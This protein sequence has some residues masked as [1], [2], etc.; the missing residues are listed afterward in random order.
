MKF[1][2]DIE[3]L[4]AVA[5]IP[6]VLFHANKQLVPGG[7]IG[8]DVFFV[9]SGFLI[10]RIIFDGVGNGSFSFFGFYRKRIQRIFPALFFML[11]II[12]ALAIWMLPPLALIEYGKT[13]FST[14]FFA[15][16]FTFSHLADYFG[17][18]AEFKP[19]LHTW[20][21]A[22]EEQFYIL[23]PVIVIAVQ[24]WLRG[25]FLPVLLACAAISLLISIWGLAHAPEKAFYSG[26]GRAFE[27][28]I[29]SLVA[30][31]F[32]PPLLSQKIRGAVA[33]AGFCAIAFSAFAFN[34]DTIFPGPAA[35]IPCLGTGAIIYAGGSGGS[36]VAGI[37]SF[38]PI[39]YIG[40]ISYSLYLWHWPFLALARNYFLN[41]MT[42]LETGAALLAAFAFAAFSREFV[43]LPFIRRNYAMKPLFA[44]AAM[45]MVAGAIL[46]QG[47]VVSRGLPARFDPE[48]TRLFAY[49]KDYNP[50][51]RQCHS[52]KRAIPYANN[53][54][55][56][57]P[58]AQE[59]VPV[60]GDSHGAELSFV[61]SAAIGNGRAVMQITA[62]ACPPALDFNPAGR[63]RCAS[64]NR[65]TLARLIADPRVHSVV[66]IAHYS[67]YLNEWQ[68]FQQGFD[69]VVLS[70]KEAGKLPIVI[71]PVPGFSYPA[72]EA[73]GIMLARGLSADAY[74]VPEEEYLKDNAKIIATLNA[75][76]AK[77]GV[78]R[79]LTASLFCKQH[80]CTAYDGK[81]VLYF[82]DNH[83]GLHGAKILAEAIAPLLSK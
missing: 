72:P 71:Y 57:D 66:L 76:I 55:F 8:V 13:L 20:S 52:G 6:V 81:D 7:F 62:S 15:S 21:L 82:D 77:Y 41:E 30:L 43:E 49:S 48:P 73:A 67:Q 78:S 18:K 24:R 34:S 27:L 45:T 1:R 14:V 68:K 36:L 61:L 47:L 58:T 28:S 79:V 35:L 65:E 54:I 63:P 70:L 75:L 74:R 44:G 38:R 17:G 69:K 12:S 60:W 23:F 42:P 29:G 53:C 10:S 64:H 2:P 4:R 31:N 16:N 50:R 5:I 40:S 33:A 22:V 19:L 39:R 83:L 11:G 56:G 3:G 32:L 59:I 46:G 80:Y 51:R 25:R 37:L 26:L 9:I